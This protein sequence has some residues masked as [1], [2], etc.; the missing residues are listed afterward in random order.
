[1]GFDVYG[2]EPEGKMGEYF[3]NNVWYWRPL[4][5][6]VCY[7]GSDLLTD[8]EKRQGSYNNGYKYSKNTA[9]AL[10]DRLRIK[11]VEGH[12]Q[13]WETERQEKLD[14]LPDEVC[15]FCNGTGERHDQ[16]VDG[17][18]NACKGKGKVRPSETWYPFEESNVIEFIEFLENCGGFEI[19]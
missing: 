17:T 2:L 12:T 9:L 16:Y 15:T 8:E 11:V 7:V 18:C 19:W 3:R 5:E 14:S 4:W 13:L 6:Y 1:M 10:A